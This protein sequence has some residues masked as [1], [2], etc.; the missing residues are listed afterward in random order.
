MG[1]D[2]VCHLSSLSV[3]ELYFSDIIQGFLGFRRPAEERGSDCAWNV[4]IPRAILHC[5]RAPKLDDIT[6]RIPEKVNDR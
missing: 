6:L 4:V 1:E 3:K 5:W 2:V